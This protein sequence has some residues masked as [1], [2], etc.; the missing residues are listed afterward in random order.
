V[1]AE[2]LAAYTPPRTPTSAA[3]WPSTPSSSAAPRRALLRFRDDVARPVRRTSTP[4]RAS[5]RRRGGRSASA[6][7]APACG[8]SAGSW[9]DLGRRHA[10]DE[11]GL[12]VRA[13]QVSRPG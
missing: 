5:R 3:C 10:D 7:P 13:Q 9:E 8:C 4:A 6:R 2:R 12:G 1:I 11:L